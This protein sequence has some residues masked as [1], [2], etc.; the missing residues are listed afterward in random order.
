MCMGGSS[1]PVQAAAQSTAE[2][3]QPTT[4]I[5]YQGQSSTTASTPG[6]T[7]GAMAGGTLL[8]GVG[9]TLSTGV[10]TAKKPTLLGQ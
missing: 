5:Q 8:T 4:K 9:E 7:S 3:S 10:K 2:P 6:G 1:R